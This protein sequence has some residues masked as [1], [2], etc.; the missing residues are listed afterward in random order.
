MRPEESVAI[1]TRSPLRARGILLGT[2]L[3][4]TLAVGVAARIASTPPK[5]SA[6]GNLATSSRSGAVQ[7]SANLDRSSVLAG[8][9]GTLRV[10]L[11]IGAD[12]APFQDGAP[13]TPT[14]LVVILDRSGSM[15]GA[16]LQF[17][18]AAVFEL[19]GQ[20]GAEDRFGLADGDQHDVFDAEV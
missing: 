3:A 2:L 14:D 4:L 17:A 13:R 6:D 7:F 15:Q 12:R 18:K 9:D 8:S 20:L 11:V 5:P 10:E 16:P 19:L 1:P